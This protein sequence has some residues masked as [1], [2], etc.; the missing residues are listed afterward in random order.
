MRKTYFIFFG[1][2]AFLIIPIMTSDAQETK[3]ISIGIN[4]GDEYPYSVT[5][6]IERAIDNYS[7]VVNNTEYIFYTTIMNIT[8]DYSLFDV[9]IIDG[10]TDEL[11]KFIR[12]PLRPILNFKNFLNRKN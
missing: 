11:V 5:E 1:L 4:G 12:H 2:V 9:Q 3:I 7:W 8:C 6:R 10:V